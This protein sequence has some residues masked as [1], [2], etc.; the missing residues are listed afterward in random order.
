MP[1]PPPSPPRQNNFRGIF[2]MLVCGVFMSAMHASIR[3]VSAGLH[4]FEIALFRI[5]FG[6]IPLL[7]WFIKLGWAPLRTKRLGLMMTRGAL[8]V[9]CMLA[10]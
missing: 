1:N 10:P 5:I 8:N 2:W 7:P 4:P 9:L 3:H 6:L